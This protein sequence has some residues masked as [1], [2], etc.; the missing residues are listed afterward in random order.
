MGKDPALLDIFREHRQNVVPLWKMNCGQVPL[1][2]HGAVLGYWAAGLV[3]QFGVEPEDWY[4]FEAG[5]G[6]LGEAS[7]RLNGGDHEKLPPTMWGQM[8]LLGLASGAS[9]FCL[10]PYTG[11]WRY[12]HPD[13]TTEAWSRVVKP[14][15]RAVVAHRLVP[16]RETAL[17]DV[18]I[19]V[20]TAPAL[21]A[22]GDDYGELKP[23]YETLYGI[24]HFAELIPDT[25]RYGIVPL[26]PPLAESAGLP[27]GMRRVSVSKLPDAAAVHAAFDPLYPPTARGDAFVRVAGDSLVVMNSRENEDIT[28]HFELSPGVEGLA[29]LSG[30]LGPHAYVVGKREHGGLWLQINGRAERAT[31]LAIHAGA[32]PSVVAVADPDALTQEWDARAGILR[33][34]I[35]HDDGAVEVR[36]EPPG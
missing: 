28:Q 13:Q 7:G 5:F 33:L 35:R 16:D 29:T 18:R 23:L 36:V 4:W 31:T 17:A 34:T 15:L 32:V 20:Q 30:A 26:L 25:G 11:I 27:A 19:A 9:C 3:D 10:E 22:F 12:G 1:S 21:P 14:L 8:L 2:I 24:R 6:G